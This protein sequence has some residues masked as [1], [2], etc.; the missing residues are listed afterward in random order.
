ME[1]GLLIR[2]GKLVPAREEQAIDLFAEG[3]EYFGKKMAE[4][5]ITFFEPFFFQ[6]SDREMD[7]GFF[8][9]KG[10]VTEVFKM[11]EEDEY[12]LLIEKA[13]VLVEH[14]QV[15]LLTVGDGIS[16]QLERSAKARAA[17]GI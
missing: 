16:L 15:D 10:P 5:V 4:G 9:V 7:T 13:M 6:T 1:I 17:L 2:Y 12:L 8:L 11:M 3:V 14:F